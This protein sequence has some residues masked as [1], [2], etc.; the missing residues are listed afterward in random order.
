[1]A[2]M[3]EYDIVVAGGGLAGLTAGLFAARHGRRVLVL[4]PAAPGGHLI[5]LPKVEDFPG[6]PEGVAGYDLGPMVQEQAAN[7]GAAFAM[8]TVTVL[9]PDGDGWI[10]VT[11]GERY[12]ASAVIVATG[13]R[14]REL[15]VPGESRLYGKGV[16]HC[17]SCD[18]P[19][20][21]GQTVGV[22]ADDEWAAQEALTLTG[23]ASE[24][25]VFLSGEAPTGQRV[26]VDRL[27]ENYRISLRPRTAVQEIVGEVGVT[28]VRV[29]D[30]TTDQESTIA[31]AAVFVYAGQEP[32]TETLRDLVS[33]DV[34]G[35]VQTDAWMR[36]ERAGLFAVGSIRADAPGLAL[37]SAADGATAAIAA[38]RY[39]AGR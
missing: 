3:D 10:V 14:L 29:R 28:G 38:H 15:G 34:A 22:V 31:L 12:W 13:T 32:N 2:L 20:Y 23:W 37:T 25:I 5:N 4:E 16:S 9:E 35:R 18:G 17:A 11:E 19:L 7:D 8:E 21:R 24:V 30:L 1:M 6:F 27:G 33:L 26:F 36:T 39:L